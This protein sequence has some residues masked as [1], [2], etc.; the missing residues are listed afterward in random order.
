MGNLELKSGHV[1]KSQENWS[2]PSPKPL[3]LTI[4]VQ[5]HESRKDQLFTSVQLSDNVL[6]VVYEEVNILNSKRG[7]L[8]NRFTAMTQSFA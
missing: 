8:P 7:G 4:Q 1:M 3:R 5:T 2:S 6:G